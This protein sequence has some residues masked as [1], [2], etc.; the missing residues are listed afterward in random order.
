[1]RLLA[2]FLALAVFV[3]GGTSLVAQSTNEKT[4]PAGRLKLAGQ[5]LRC[6]HTPTLMSTSFWDYGGSYTSSAG[7]GMIILNPNKLETLPP[8]VQLYVYEHE[9]GH[10]LRGRSETKADCYAVERGR[11]AGWLTSDG[12]EAICAFFAAHP[13]DSVHPPGPERCA[14]MAQCFEKAKPRARR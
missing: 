4:I 1:M 12:V 11:R 8:I 6:G 7:R 5:T 9:C 10:Q 14:A 2:A 3:A 13:T